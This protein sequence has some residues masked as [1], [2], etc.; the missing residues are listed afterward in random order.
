M[1]GKK[2]RSTIRKAVHGAKKLN[3]KYKIGKKVKKYGPGAAGAAIALGGVA[4]AA[5]TGNTALAQAGQMVGSTL[6][7]FGG[8]DDKKKKA[9]EW[10]PEH[11]G[12]RTPYNQSVHAAVSGKPSRHDS[13]HGVAASP[14]G[15]ATSNSNKPHNAAKWNALVSA[16][17][18][19]EEE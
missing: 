15:A 11:G 19:D 5:Y 1:A 2:K 9:A 12:G 6:S 3:K 14:T 17:D 18:W 7:G 16:T 4:A 8:G 10:V 13:S